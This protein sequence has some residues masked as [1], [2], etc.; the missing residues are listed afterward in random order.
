MF[1]SNDKKEEATLT[2]F[3]PGGQSNQPQPGELQQSLLQF[4]NSYSLRLIQSLKDV[5]DAKNSSFTEEEALTFKISS[6]GTVITIV[7]G[8]NPNVNL[9]NLVA[10]SSLSRM[11]LEDYWVKQPNGAM[12]EPWLQNAKAQEKKI[13][14]IAEMVITKQQQDELRQSIEKEYES[15]KGQDKL[16]LSHPQDL[17]TSKSLRDGG[18]EK[19][20][21]SLATI[22]PF[23]GLDPTV[24]EITQTR[25][26]AERAL[27]TMQWMPWL[28]RW[29]SE[30]LVLK[31]TNQ[32]E[33][34]QTLEDL[35]S[36]SESIDRA[37]KAA[38]SLSVTANAL[39]DQIAT[40]REAIVKALDTQEGQIT[41]MLQAGNEMS[42][43]LTSTIDSL[44]A[45]M[46]RFGVGE[47]RDPNKP[48]RDPNKKPFDIL[49]Y[50]KT[51]DS[52]TAT[53]EQ[54][55]STLMEL[56]TTLDSPALDKLSEKA[57]ADVRG[58]LNHLFILAGGLVLLIF[59]CA[60][61][62]RK[63]TKTKGA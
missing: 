29:Q 55:N 61:V 28:L 23:S 12:F 44:D 27:Y 36:L 37:S 17:I 33:V 51:A 58:V 18:N 41:T 4:A 62:Y 21:F 32:P 16:F 53:A 63:I 30:L 49:D 38:E 9:L 46:K 3:F 14:S 60:L 24:R 5:E 7:T 52:F 35:T 45:L 19:S 56:N 40:E 43:S 54:L 26:F 31:T 20:L 22:N 50:A 2:R 15:L 13:W 8:E 47:P 34:S 10:L 48:P 1:R 6:I 39:P 59:T 57:T 25:L 11:V 42:T